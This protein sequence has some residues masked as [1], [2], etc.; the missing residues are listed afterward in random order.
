MNWPV[1]VLFYG[2]SSWL[3]R[4]IQRL[5]RSP[6]S[7]AA[8]YLQ[9][10]GRLYEAL[11]RG[12]ILRVGHEAHERAG[13]AKAS[14]V[15]TVNETDYRQMRAFLDRRVNDRYAFLNFVAAGI[16]TLFPRL[17]LVM[18]DGRKYICSGLVAEALC[19]G[20]FDFDEPALMTPGDLARELGVTI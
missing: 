1:I 4:V 18:S 2:G 14:V 3:S 11:G 10:S 15:V 9:T 5:T 17:P 16:N 8:I 6:Y 12:I 13:K 7:H 19:K 20:D